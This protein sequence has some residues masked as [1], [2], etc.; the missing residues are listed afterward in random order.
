MALAR[1]NLLNTSSPAA[2]FASKLFSKRKAELSAL[3]SGQLDSAQAEKTKNRVDFLARFLKAQKDHPEFMTDFQVL[4][5][6][7][8]LVF[9][10]SDTTA[11]SLSSMFYFLLRNP[12]VYGKLMEEIDKAVEDGTILPHPAALVTWTSAQ[13]LTYLDA[14]I[15]ESFRLFPAVGLLLE[16]HVPPGGAVICGRHVPGGTIVGCNAWVLHRRKD[17]F[18]EDADVYRPERWLEASPSKRNEMK[19]TMFQFGAGARTCIGRNISTLEVYKLVPS[20]LRRFEIDWV[21]E[22]SDWKTENCW[23]VRQ[24]DFMVRFRP[25][26]RRDSISMN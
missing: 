24:L 20:F 14:C 7:V 4:T 17:V 8:S 1:F 11:I 16:R 25:R 5:A 18:G 2:K 23:F 21:D 10:G 15:Q 9:A 13:K 19:A 6:T 3:E 22:N 12:R 26:K